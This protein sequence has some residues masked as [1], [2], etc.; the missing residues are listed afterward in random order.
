MS[1]IDWTVLL[2]TQFLIIGYGAWRSRGSNKDIKNYLLG[3]NQM[4]W[5]TIG[6]S[7]M[8]TQASAVTFL[9][10]P[11]QAFYDGMGFIQIYFGLPIAMV[12]LCITAI[13]I[14]HKLGVYTAYEYLENRFDLNTRALAALL[15]LIQ[16][17]L[18]TGITIYA[19]SLVLSTVL[20]WDIYWTIIL[21]GIVV[22]LYTYLGGTKAVSYTQSQQTVVIWIGMFAALYILITNLPT[23]L[24]F[25]DIWHLAGN[26]N[27]TEIIDLSFD[28]S[29][30]Y[31][32][33]SGLLGGIFLSLSYFGT[34]QSQVQR[35]LGGET[36]TQSRLGLLMNAVVKI[37]MQF[38]ILFL[39]VLLF[40]FYQFV[41]QPVFF[42]ANEVKKVYLS[43]QKEA[44]Q[45]VETE[46]NNVNKQKQKA[47]E[48]YL[49]L[50]Q[51][52]VNNLPQ[53]FTT[54]KLIEGLDAE[55]KQLHKKAAEII[56]KTNNKADTKDSDYVFI[57][58]ITSYLPIGL[59]GLLVSVMIS[60]SMG[61]AASA[62]NALASTTVIDIYK[63]LLKQQ[64]SP[65]HYLQVSKNLSL[66]WGVACILFA[67]FVSRL[68]NMIQAVNILGS[69]FYGTVLGIFLV[70]FYMKKVDGKAVFWS[71]VV[72]ETIILF[73]FFFFRE[74]IAYL[75]YNAI[76][77][78]LVMLFSYVAMLFR[79]PLQKNHS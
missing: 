4:S 30:R 63:R 8:A 52:E 41:P 69:L 27:K 1:Y 37:P 54:L 10:I 78:L 35:Y 31:T 59:I 19:P 68:D 50:R 67:I 79:Q 33:W 21:M 71:A 76:G 9:S 46:F 40:V 75:W 20:G 5:L 65:E 13:P 66:F 55:A 57:S 58:F 51:D 53:M 24:S 45:A 23:H 28:P 15:F 6:V 77:C 25:S 11:G 29:D 64:A 26:M 74:E 73:C 70:A 39:G 32:L 7:V 2:L 56:K 62:F 72:T 17:G 42:N 34:D 47:I 38:F 48:T 36:V 49:H 60:A 14:Y 12:I 43:P 22:T 44:Y 3:N 18:S 61:S 16:R